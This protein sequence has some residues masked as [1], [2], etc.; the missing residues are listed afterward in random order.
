MATLTLRISDEMNERLKATAAEDHRS[1]NSQIIY[2]LDHS[3]AMRDEIAENA[4]AARRN[5]SRRPS[6]GDW[7]TAPRKGEHR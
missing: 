7:S 1:L 2:F 5:S 4:E 3:L 6:T